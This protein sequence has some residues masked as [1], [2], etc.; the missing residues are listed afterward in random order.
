MNDIQTT[1][2]LDTP[3]G[4]G[5]KRALEGNYPRPQPEHYSVSTGHR[6][7]HG[8]N[9]PTGVKA[10]HLF[11]DPL[12][13]TKAGALE[14]EFPDDSTVINL[15]VEE[16]NLQFP[17]PSY[18]CKVNFRIKWRKI[19]NVN[20]PGSTNV[21]S[22]MELLPEDNVT[23]IP[24]ADKT[25]LN[26]AFPRDDNN[27]PGAH[28]IDDA[29]LRNGFWRDVT[30]WIKWSG[31]DGKPGDFAHDKIGKLHD[32]TDGRIAAATRLIKE[33]ILERFN[34]AGC[35]MKDGTFQS[36]VGYPSLLAAWDKGLSDS[37]IRDLIDEYLATKPAD[38]PAPENGSEN[39]RGAALPTPPAIPIAPPTPAPVVEASSA[40]P[41][42][43]KEQSV[44]YPES[45]IVV[46]PFEHGSVIYKGIRFSVT[47]R[48]GGRF[49]DALPLMDDFVKAHESKLI[50]IDP[51]CLINR[52]ATVML[53]PAPS[54]SAPAPVPVAPAPA[55]NSGGTVHVAA[56]KK[57]V[58]EGKT[59]YEL[60]SG[61]TSEKPALTVRLDSVVRDVIAKHID[62]NA[63][64]IGTRYQ[65][66]WTATYTTSE[67][68]NEQANKTITYRNLATITP[69]A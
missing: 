58:D 62:V 3:L 17:E 48:L 45:P 8:H 13:K 24:V 39:G 5:A 61:M 22:E 50:E 38:P 20:R 1:L 23:D 69:A 21:A 31:W 41:A 55:A 67:K 15:F 53:P 46:Y 19:R 14:V 54:A 56:I 42:P 9:K 36:A 16:H 7:V 27:Q 6:I 18:S 52:P 47:L 63:L 25:T 68:F 10:W 49:A 26:E 4:A 11:L 44:N 28:W 30:P 32:W 33:A 57:I 65:V 2:T 66:N 29:K 34:K 43:V 12:D 60:F 37:Y 64:Q 35:E 51:A 59:R 40:L